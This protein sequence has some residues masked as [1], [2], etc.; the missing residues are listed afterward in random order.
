[1]PC[2]ASSGGSSFKIDVITSAAVS[3]ENGRRPD[4]ISW[5]TEPK[6]KMSDRWSAGA[7]LTC[8]GDM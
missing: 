1:M 6:E 3:P 7:P 2:L 5:N 4:S 8:S